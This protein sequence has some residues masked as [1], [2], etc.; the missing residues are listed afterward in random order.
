[1]IYCE[2]SFPISLKAMQQFCLL[3]KKVLMPPKDLFRNAFQTVFT[4]V[5]CLTGFQSSGC[6]KFYRKQKCASAQFSDWSFQSGATMCMATNFQPNSLGKGE[7]TDIDDGA[8]MND[9]ASQ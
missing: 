6:S 5:H 7:E 9:D 8:G 2:S 1:M 3:K 4:A